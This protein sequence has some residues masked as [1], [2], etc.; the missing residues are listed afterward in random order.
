MDERVAQYLRLYSC[1]FQTTV[2]ACHGSHI[3]SSLS[4]GSQSISVL[5]LKLKF[6][7]TSFIHSIQTGYIF[8]NCYIRKYVS[9]YSFLFILFISF[10][11]ISFRFSSKYAR[12]E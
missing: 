12:A 11:L 5:I 1:L 4:N 6:W 7:H 9:S 10:H 8:A 2:H 3:M